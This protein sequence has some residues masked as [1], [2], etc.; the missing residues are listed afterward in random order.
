MMR[1]RKSPPQLDPR[2]EKELSYDTVLE[3]MK[4]QLRQL[5][6]VEMATPESQQQ[7][8]ERLLSLMQQLPQ[9]PPWFQ[10]LLTNKPRRPALATKPG[11]QRSNPPHNPAAKPPAENAEP[12]KPSSQSS[13]SSVGP[14]VVDTPKQEN[15][16][17]PR[18]VP[19]NPSQ[20]KMFGMGMSAVSASFGPAFA[21]IAPKL[22]P[23]VEQGPHEPKTAPV[24][25]RP[26]IPM[27][28]LRK[29]PPRVSIPDTEHGVSLFLILLQK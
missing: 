28:F 23:S 8:I 5:Q 4:T 26:L 6:E 9:T 21:N 10:A 17:H 16:Q 12:D 19:N 7:Q 1:G 11:G 25:I 18:E 24:F 27:P 13:R 22:P 3:E 15:S 2:P 29:E 14:D 20:R